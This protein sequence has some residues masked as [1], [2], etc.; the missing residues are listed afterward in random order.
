MSLRMARFLSE[1]VYGSSVIGRNPMQPNREGMEG[2]SNDTIKGGG[3]LYFS[4]TMAID[5]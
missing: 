5:G 2:I 4:R 3:V 1:L